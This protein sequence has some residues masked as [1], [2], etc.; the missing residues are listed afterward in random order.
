MELY[1]A[2]SLQ[3]GSVKQ[4]SLTVSNLRFHNLHVLIETLS[5]MLLDLF[6]GSLLLT[7]IV[8]TAGRHLRTVHQ[9]CVVSLW[10]CKLT[11]R[12]NIL[13]WV[14]EN[15]HASAPWADLGL[16]LG[17][18]AQTQIMDDD[19]DLAA[20]EFL[21]ESWHNVVNS[22]SPALGGISRNP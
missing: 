3:Q 20:K 8:V 17:T 5:S 4:A 15:S 19:L 16:F 12:T 14:L 1:C 21:Y 2:C 11:T 10:L 9:I 6:W 18:L 7:T 13:G 22:R